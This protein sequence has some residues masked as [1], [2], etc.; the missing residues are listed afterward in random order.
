MIGGLEETG[1]VA[2][3]GWVVWHWRVIVAFLFFNHNTKGRIFTVKEGT[4]TNTNTISQKPKAKNKKRAWNLESESMFRTVGN[5]HTKKSPPAPS[6]WGSLV[7]WMLHRRCQC[8]IGVHYPGLSLFE[9]NVPKKALVQCVHHSR[10]LGVVNKIHI[11]TR[12]AEGRMH[13]R[14]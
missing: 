5:V 14:T 10:I 2:K 13:M 3:A 6:A 12:P 9:L 4:N 7:L 11:F 1:K 8:A